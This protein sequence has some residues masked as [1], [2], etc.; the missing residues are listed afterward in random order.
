MR[1]WTDGWC[2]GTAVT[3]TVAMR[4]MCCFPNNRCYAVDVLLLWQPLLCSGCAS[5]ITIVAMRWMRCFH[6]NRCKSSPTYL[7]VHL[8]R[9]DVSLMDQF[10]GPDVFH[11]SFLYQAHW[12]LSIPPPC[13]TCPPPENTHHTRTHYC[14]TIAHHRH[15]LLCP[16]C[17]FVRFGSLRLSAFKHLNLHACNCPLLNTSICMHVIVHF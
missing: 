4:W 13:H 17:S 12:H 14:L 9:H 3:R 5:F 15:G 11:S 7:F 2:R 8:D 16:S 6:D 10:W 1:F